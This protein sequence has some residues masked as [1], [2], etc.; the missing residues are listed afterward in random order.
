MRFSVRECFALL[1]GQFG[2]GGE[3]ADPQP[4]LESCVWQ[5]PA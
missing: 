2:A 4:G 5:R 1:I 3:P